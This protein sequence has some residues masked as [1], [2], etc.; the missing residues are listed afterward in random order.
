MFVPQSKTR[1]WIKRRSHKI[2]C[3]K[4]ALVRITINLS[5][6]YGLDIS[7]TWIDNKDTLTTTGKTHSQTHVKSR[8]RHHLLLQYYCTTPIMFDMVSLVFLQP[9]WHSLNLCKRISFLPVI[10]PWF[11]AGDAIKI[12]SQIMAW[13]KSS[14]KKV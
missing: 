13:M 5:S 9:I 8:Q 2:I 7:M 14:A 11:S 3:F 4:H 12:F 6:H 10:G 1:R